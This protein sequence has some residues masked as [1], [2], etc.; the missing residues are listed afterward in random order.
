MSKIIYFAKAK[1]RLI[2]KQSTYVWKFSII[3]EG[4][5]ISTSKVDI[6]FETLYI[7]QIFENIIKGV[8]VTLFNRNKNFKEGEY[9]INTEE[10][11]NKEFVFYIYSSE[12]ENF[13][14][15]FPKVDDVLIGVLLSRVL[16][17]HWV[18]QITKSA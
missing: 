17:N 4:D 18:W 7:K 3:A 6:E 15:Y 1:Q 16:Q 11:L 9:K 8:L 2:L 5:N 13:V 12:N 10:I 14:E